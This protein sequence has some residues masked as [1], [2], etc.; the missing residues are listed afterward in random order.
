[1]NKILY[2]PCPK[3]GQH[4]FRKLEYTDQAL[5]LCGSCGHLTT[6]ATVQKKT[7]EVIR[8]KRRLHRERVREQL[9]ERDGISATDSAAVD[10][11]DGFDYFDG[12]GWISFVFI[13]VFTFVG[14]FGVTYFV[15]DFLN[16]AKIGSLAS[17]A[18]F[19]PLIFLFSMLSMFYVGLLLCD[20]KTLD[21]EDITIRAWLTRNFQMPLQLLMDREIVYYYGLGIVFY[22]MHGNQ[23]GFLFGLMLVV[24]AADLI[25]GLTTRTL[26]STC[27]NC[28]ATELRFL[29]DADKTL[30]CMQCRKTYGIGEY[31]SSRRIRFSLLRRSRPLISRLKRRH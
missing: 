28:G 12:K 19:G 24:V 2:L 1:M 14:G 31:N 21:I 9:S 5:H 26:Y 16:E 23:Y 29:D 18:A 17:A 8:S 13:M 30:Q 15:F 7:I 10:D 25:F 3:C 6:G 11:D 20:V 22:I 4:T 27:L